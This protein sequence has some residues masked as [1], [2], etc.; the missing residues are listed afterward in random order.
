MGLSEVQYTTEALYRSSCL[1]LKHQRE[2][3]FGTKLKFIV[4]VWE[5]LDDCQIPLLTSLVKNTLI[6]PLGSKSVNYNMFM[7]GLRKHI[8]LAC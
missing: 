7:E 6:N 3:L 8:L 2:K 5:K 4:S 1:A